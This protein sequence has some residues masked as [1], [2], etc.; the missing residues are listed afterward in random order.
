M[1]RRKCTWT[2]ECCLHETGNSTNGWRAKGWTITAAEPRTVQGQPDL[3]LGARPASQA[4]SLPSWA[5]ARIV[6][7]QSEPPGTAFPT[8][9]TRYID[10]ARQVDRLAESRA[11]TIGDQVLRSTIIFLISAM[12]L[13][14]F[15]PFGQVWAQLRMV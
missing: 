7:L 2:M 1:A 4:R 12:A 10:F 5:N 14:G 13:A 8:A 15:N 9:H 3:R 6:P 11:T